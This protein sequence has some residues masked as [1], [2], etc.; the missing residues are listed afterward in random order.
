[1]QPIRD[2]VTLGFAVL[3]ITG[4]AQAQNTNTHVRVIKPLKQDLSPPFRDMA[5]ASGAY[6]DAPITAG[7]DG[8]TGLASPKYLS[9][10]LSFGGMPSTGAYLDADPNGAVGTTQ[11]VQWTNVRYAV[12]NKATGVVIV[13]PTSAKSLWSGFGGSCSTTNSGDGLVVFDKVAQRW[14]ITHHAGSWPYLLCF[15]IS[16]TSDASG[17]YYRYS[18]QLTNQ[19]PDWPKVGVWP[20]AYYITMNLLNP[21]SFA[22]LGAEVCA[23][24]RISMLAG[25]KAATAQCFTTGSANTN[26]VL[27]PA[28]LDGVTPPPTGSP[29]YLLSLNVN[30]LDFYKFHVDWITPSHSVLTGPIKIP[31][32]RFTNGCNGGYCVPQLGTTNLLD[33]VGERLMWRLAY[34]NFGN[35]ESLIVNHA[36]NN[37][38]GT[39]VGIRWYEIRSPGTTPSIYQSGTL[40]PDSAFRTMG[41]MAMDKMGNML[42]GYSK[43][44]AS[45]YPT[46]AFAGRF[47]T[48]PLGTLQ[49]ESTLVSGTGAQTGNDYHWGD[50]TSMTVDPIDDCTLWYTN[51]YYKTSG[52][53]WA[54]RIGAFKFN[55]CQ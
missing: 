55:G 18:F 28:D 16:A 43:S 11:Y 31:V 40:Q 20:D 49:P 7:P 29:N 9:I 26:Y 46:I 1:M 10:V 2:A 42:I 13:P 30:S 48:D 50:Y 34:R 12:Y 39:S 45:M 3:L 33:A 17:P 23:L 54:T 19:F 44:S 38:N 25:S 4:S 53:L 22:S 6:A 21:A 27:E 24:A 5:A 47:A 52:T 15:A 14:V 41:S 35:H 8:A 36:I 32:T 37:S 51:E